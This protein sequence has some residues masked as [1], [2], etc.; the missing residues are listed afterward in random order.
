MPCKIC[1]RLEQA[2]VAAAKPD[3]PD[4][5]LGLT[6]AGMRNRVLQKEE[7]LLKAETDLENHQRSCPIRGNTAA[8]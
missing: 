8:F 3:P 6:Q 7:R 4:I 1:I 5:L 2:A